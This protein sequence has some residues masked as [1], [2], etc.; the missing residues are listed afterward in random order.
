MNHLESAFVG[1]N[2]WWAYLL[3]FVMSFV[4]AQLVGGIPLGIVLNMLAE[5]DVDY[6]K[7]I[8]F[9]S[10][11]I[12]AS[13]GLALM[14]LPFIISFFVFCYMMKPVHK[15][16]F[17]SVING[18]YNIRK[19]RIIMGFCLWG[20]IIAFATIVDYYLNISEYHVR[21]DLTKLLPLILVSLL[22]LPFQAF[23]EE[24]L[25]RGYFAQGIGVLTHSRV[26]VLII[27]SL[28]FALLHAI[29]PEVYKHGFIL[30]MAMY[31]S[32]GLI[33]AIVSVLDDGIELAMGAHAANNIFISIFV[34]T[35]SSVL[36]TDALLLSLND[37][38][39]WFDVLGIWLIGFVFI[40]VFAFK[41][42]WSLHALFKRI[43]RPNIN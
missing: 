15:R 20:L 9:N 5:G 24:L 8:D 17:K 3:V 6:G 14:L 28:L 40:G 26:L 10:Y 4:L 39:S 37:K 27:P 13:L 7:A 2:K 22:M 41:Y 16:A 32:T 30:M 31:F 42:K 43:E 19:Y 18:T 35:E 36:Q 34:S 38:Q 11:G 23:Y 29:N 33:F 12:N 25:V 1:N 21:F